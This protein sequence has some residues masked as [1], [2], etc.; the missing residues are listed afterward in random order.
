VIGKPKAVA[1]QT[2]E[3]AGYIVAVAARSCP[4]YPIGYVCDQTP[5]PGAQGT[6][7]TNATIYVSDDQAVATV[8]MVLGKTLAQATS[9]LQSKGFKVEVVTMQNP[10]GEFAV[11]GC[12][13]PNQAGDKRVW[14]QTFCAGEE[15]PKGSLVRIYVNP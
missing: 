8:P 13:D 7:G 11:G 9:V 10:E 2:L 12:R 14:L 3:Q 5:E 4:S 1:I 15:R 6:V